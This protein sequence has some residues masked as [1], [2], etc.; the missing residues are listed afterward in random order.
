MFSFKFCKECDSPID[1]ATGQ[2]C[3]YK[4]KYDG[5]MLEDRPKKT[6]VIKFYAFHHEEKWDGKKE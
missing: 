2:L 3:S 5:M 6:I 1:M 4:C